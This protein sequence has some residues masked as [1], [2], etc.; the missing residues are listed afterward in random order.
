MPHSSP[1]PRTCSACGNVSSGEDR[2]CPKCGTT[3]TGLTPAEH[4]EISQAPTVATP[5][6]AGVTAPSPAGTAPPLSAD[7]LEEQLRAALSPSFLLVRK[8][9]EGGMGAVFLA[10]DPALKRNVVV[11]VLSPALAIDESARRRFERE[12]ESAA[13][14]AHPNVVSIFQVGELPRSGTSYFVMQYVEGQTLEAACPLGAPVPVARAKRIVGEIASALAAAHARGLVHRDIKPANVMLEVDTD[15]VVVLDFGISAAVSPERQAQGGTKLTQQ[16]TSIGTPQYMSPEQAAG[17]SVTDRSDVYSLGLVAFE[18]LAGKAVFEERTPMALLAAHIHREPTKIATLRAELEPAFADLVDRCLLKE[19]EKRPAAADVARMLVPPAQPRIEWPPPGL[20][21]AHGRGWVVTKRAVW[22]AISAGAAFG[23]L[24]LQPAIGTAAWTHGETSWLWRLLWAPQL[25]FE[26]TMVRPV[27]CLR[28]RE[29]GA[30]CP[31]PPVDA[32]PLWLFAITVAV[33]LAAVGLAAVVAGT[34]RLGVALRV[35]RRAGYP[36]H[37]FRAVAWDS[38]PDTEALL[39]ARGPYALAAEAERDELQRRRRLAQWWLVSGAA[40]TAALPLLWWLGVSVIGDAGVRWVTAGEVLLALAPLAA[41]LVGRAVALRPE[42]RLRR[43]FRR[44]RRSSGTAT[45]IALT[46]VDGWLAA[47]GGRA[48]PARRRTL[49]PA[50][51]LP[52]LMAS[53]AVLGVLPILLG[54]HG[55]ALWYGPTLRGEMESWLTLQSY[56]DNSW[57]AID[58][59]LAIQIARIPA[60]SREAGRVAKAGAVQHPNVRPVVDDAVFAAVRDDTSWTWLPRWRETVAQVSARTPREW[61]RT[62]RIAVGEEVVGDRYHSHVEL[63]TAAAELAFLAG[64]TQTARQR[65]REALLVGR[66]TLREAEPLGRGGDDAGLVGRALLVHYRMLLMLL[67]DT[68]GERLTLP[69]L[70]RLWIYTAAH[71][72]LYALTPHTL[73]ADPDSPPGERG[74]ADQRVAPGVRKVLAR[75]AVVGLCFNGREMLFGM[76]SRRRALIERVAASALD[77]PTVGPDV[78]ALAADYD[79]KAGT[80]RS[81]LGLPARLRWCGDAG[82]VR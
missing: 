47:A 48:P 45:S 20:E 13:A 63:A 61:D 51:G 65:I 11:K 18:L 30:I 23:L 9:G 2:F 24:L 50:L 40:I 8:L 7:S 31:R 12:A 26:Y 43:R 72:A 25:V 42:R 28:Y 62:P 58:S 10:R 6:G 27:V 16:G 19:P 68:V 64:D 37:V 75:G 29:V 46:L 60:A 76:S 81:I 69:T 39:N 33:L 59:M 54:V 67:G 34:V 70:Q 74:V 80:R 21:S 36:W 14:V 73:M 57:Q 5:S 56:P 53:L 41:G 35:A 78:R 44:A 79:R 77:L 4:L 1:A 66:Y 52:L 82:A 71:Q 55:W 17:E 38:G 22:T 15:R 49:L 32:L 3:L